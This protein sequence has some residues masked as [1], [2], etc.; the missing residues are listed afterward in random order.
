MY[1]L[2]PSEYKVTLELFHQFKEAF[3]ALPSYIQE[4]FYAKL[5]STRLED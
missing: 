4:A 3:D 1:Y 5:Y 2:T